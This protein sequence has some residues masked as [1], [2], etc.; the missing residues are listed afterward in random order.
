MKNKVNMFIWW[1]LWLAY[2]E[3]I[4]K[5]F[6]V[7]NLFTSNTISV[8]IFCLPWTII[9]SMLTSL[10]NN[11][12]NRIINIVLTFTITIFTL[13]QIVYFNFYHSIFSFFSFTTGTGQVFQFYTYIIEVILRIWYIFV[14]TLL[15]LLLV[16]IYSK[17]IFNYDRINKKQ[18]LYRLSGLLVSFLLVFITIKVDN[19]KYPLKRLLFETHAPMLTINKTGLFTMEVIDIFRYYNGFEEKISVYDIDSSENN[20]T[21]YNVLNIDFDSLIEEEKDD[22]IKQMHYY[23]KNVKPSNKNEYTGLLKDKNIIFIAA[24]SLDPIAIDEELTPTL[25][26]LA[27]NGFVFNNYYQPLYPISTFDG[28]FMLL[29]SLIPKEGE[30]SLAS[31]SSNSMP[32]ALGNMFKNINYNTL[33]YHNNVYSFYHRE[34]SHTNIGFTYVACGNGIEKLMNCDNWPN[35]DYEMINST[36]NSYINGDKFATY[37]MTFSGHL[38]YNFRE[39]SMSIKNEDAVKDLPYSNKIKSYLATNIELDKA[40]EDLLNKLESNNKLDDTLIVISPDHYPYGLT[41]KQMNEISDTDRGNKFENYHT[42]LIMY[43]PNIEKTY[44]DKVVSGLD[45]LPT[46][47]NLF[48]IEYDSRLLM[49][50]DI[51]SDEEHIVIFSDRSWITDKCAYNSLT[52]TCENGFNDQDY[53]SNINKIVNDRFSMSS[54][55][56][57]K[58]YYS[59]LGY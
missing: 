45:V 41:S 51:F 7:K 3:L 4:Y 58:D 32:F 6:V 54:L 48:G 12:V 11:K 53:I 40:L 28:E 59:K 5:L 27:N 22:T 43:N 56:I 57:D 17:K 10:F 29:T 1:L 55:I 30:W 35:S 34:K 36:V 50:R 49:G 37:Y 42:T 8:L 26:K 16:L 25:Y 52:G 38:N 2:I 13:A 39:N 19:N 14:L 31:T 18:V 33:A 21:K 44:V 9:F 23:F 15:P 24:E 47:Y 20:N 46:I